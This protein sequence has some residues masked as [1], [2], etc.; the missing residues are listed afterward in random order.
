MRDL[1]WMGEY[2]LEHNNNSI[3]DDNLKQEINERFNKLL[4]QKE[5]TTQPIDIEFRKS[6]T[7]IIGF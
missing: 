3:S 2:S 5:C 1:K 6:P 4:S 7:L